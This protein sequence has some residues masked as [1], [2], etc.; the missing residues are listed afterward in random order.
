MQWPNLPEDYGNGQ[1]HFDMAK[2][3]YDVAEDSAWLIAGGIGYGIYAW[4][5]IWWIAIPASVAAYFIYI[6]P[7]KRNLEVGRK[8]WQDDIR[9]YHEYLDSKA[10]AIDE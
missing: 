10:N 2:A 5:H 6:T 4:W 8:L 9:A 1:R 3:A 7:Y